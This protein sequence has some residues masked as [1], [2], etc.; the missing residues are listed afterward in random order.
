MTKWKITTS[1]VKVSL[2]FEVHVHKVGWRD[3][4]F[5][6]IFENLHISAYRVYFQEL[7]SEIFDVLHALQSFHFQKIKW[8]LKIYLFI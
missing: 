7:N 2:I 3:L 5:F 8:T 6:S 1:G 4:A